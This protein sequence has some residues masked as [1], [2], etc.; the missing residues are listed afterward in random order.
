MTA[1][2]SAVV[3]IVAAL[4]SCVQLLVGRS[5][6]RGGILSAVMMNHWSAE[7]VALRDVVYGLGNKEYAQWSEEERAA[8]TAVGIQISQVGFLLRN[9]YADR[10]AFLDFWSSWC[11][12][13][14][15][16]LSPMIADL[17]TRQNAPDQWIYFEWLARKAYRHTLRRPWWQRYA[18]ASLKRQTRQLPDPDVLRS[19]G[20]PRTRATDDDFAT[21]PEAGEKG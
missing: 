15:V 7:N 9:S 2:I 21:R 10:R 18:W 11:V 1:Q 6:S 5:V 12:R 16:I 8:A 17:R 13:L 4:I 14:F 20:H 3:A 19:A